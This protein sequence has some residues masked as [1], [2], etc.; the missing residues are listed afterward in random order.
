MMCPMLQ[1]KEMAYQMVKYPEESKFF[2]REV[3]K[4]WNDHG[5]NVLR[6]DKYTPDY[7]YNRVKKLLCTEIIE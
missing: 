3:F 1:Y 7:I 4:M 2:W 5:I 6:G